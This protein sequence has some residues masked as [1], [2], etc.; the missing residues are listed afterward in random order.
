VEP[1]LVLAARY[2][3]LAPI[4]EGAA[5]T[6]WEARDRATGE[7]VAV[8]AVSMERAGWRAEVR[9]RF[10]QEARLLTMVQDPHLVRV[11]DL[12]ETDDGYLY[13]VLDRLSGETLAERLARP[14]RLDWRAAA[15]V[16][17]ELAC[18]LEALHAR[19]VVH[20]DLKPANVILHRPSDAGGAGAPVAKI[21]DLGISKVSAAAADPV[22]FAT[23]TAT[24]QV[25]GTPE[26]MSHEQALGERDVDVRTDVWALGVVLHEMLAGRRPFEGRNPNAVLAAIRRGPPPGLAAAS[27]A[28]PEALG[29]VIRRCLARSREARYRDGAELRAALADA[30]RLG[31]AEERRTARRRWLALGVGAALLAGA[32]LGVH[33]LRG[34]PPSAPPPA[35][36]SAAVPARRVDT[37]A[38]APATA[39]PS[40]APAPSG[41][42]SAPP[43]AN[44]R[45]AVTRVN[46]A[47]F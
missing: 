36:P 24:G 16:A 22:L 32:G 11:R 39:V 3:I 30:I 12:G 35:P 17:L 6:V 33:A 25:L 26:Y 7:A 45:R 29:R 23:L 19:G 27:R 14:P 4:A 37:S 2:E 46:T 34:H 5:S 38:A 9:D 13:I 31:E 47:G 20:R 15:G 42:S 10:Q 43:P 18:G 28:M 44:G 40:A 8:K 21:I 41:T 1:G